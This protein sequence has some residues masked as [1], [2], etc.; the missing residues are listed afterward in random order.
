[1]STTRS[2]TMS[3]PAAV[4]TTPLPRQRVELDPARQIEL[5]VDRHGAR[6][7]NGAAAGA[8]KASKGSCWSWIFRSDSSTDIFPV[9]TRS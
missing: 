8:R 9:R 1:M 4:Q 2:L 5:P 6:S 3:S 7:A